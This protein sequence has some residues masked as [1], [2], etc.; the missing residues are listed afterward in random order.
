MVL[1]SLDD[2]IHVLDLAPFL[3]VIGLTFAHALRSF[4]D[5]E[6]HTLAAGERA[7]RDP[8]F[9]ESTRYTSP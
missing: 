5:F 7:R 8:A 6:A 9:A 2:H 3:F 1:P 4:E